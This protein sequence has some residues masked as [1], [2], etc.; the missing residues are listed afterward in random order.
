MTAIDLVLIVLATA[1]ITRMITRD[2]LTEPLRERAVI[3]LEAQERQW[4]KVAYL[5]QCDWCASVYAGA[6][7]AGTSVVFHGNIW[8]MAAL[9]A[10]AASHVTGFMASRES[11]E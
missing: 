9:A 8:Y 11:G 5:I 3:W 4:D 10:L 2:T 7:V 6:A 1:R